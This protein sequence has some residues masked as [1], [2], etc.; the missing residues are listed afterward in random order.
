MNLSLL[1]RRYR[2]NEDVCDLQYAPSSY[3]V[4]D[5]DLERMRT[6][7]TMTSPH[8]QASLY[9]KFGA[10]GARL[11]SKQCYGSVPA[12]AA[13]CVTLTKSG[14]RVITSCEPPPPHNQRQL[15]HEHNVHVSGIE[16]L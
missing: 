13:Y 7:H 6:D 11:S 4:P 8:A 1:C 15:C 2:R 3:Y 9:E 12:T 5:T 16:S 14:E 10:G